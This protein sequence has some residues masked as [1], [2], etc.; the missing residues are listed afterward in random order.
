MTKI[1]L[2]HGSA[3]A[4][5]RKRI[6]EIKNGFD[7][8]EVMEISGKV[9]LDEIILNLSTNLLFSEKRLIILDS[10]IDEFNLE[11]I[12][13]DPNL[14]LVFKF[15]RQLTSTNKFIKQ[16]A[17]KGAQIILFNEEKEQSIFPFLDLLAE[18]NPK[19]FKYLSKLTN[20]YGSQ[21]IF[22][23]VFFLL[24]RLVVSPKNTPPFVQN[25]LNSQRKN[26][27]KERISML[28]KQII[29]LDFKLKTGLLDEKNALTLMCNLLLS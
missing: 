2:L 19:A 11:K 16:A 13:E 21:Y 29:G 15:D 3:Q 20:D 26:F 18:K 8:L 7:S 23:M 5:L 9:S 6:S 24:R 17:Q 10:Q 28:Y 25:K 12:P 4:L 22:T 27:P 14:S 1:L